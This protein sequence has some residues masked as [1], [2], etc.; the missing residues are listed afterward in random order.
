MIKNK[1]DLTPDACLLK[2]EIKIQTVID[3]I[4]KEI[5]PYRVLLFGS[6]ATEMAKPDSDIDLIV[7]L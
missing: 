1:T 5:K 4:K 6:Q 7:W 2:P 3:V